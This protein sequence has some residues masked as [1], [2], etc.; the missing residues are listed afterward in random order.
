MH[1]PGDDSK[2]IPRA[3][4]PDA[5]ILLK[6]HTFF[7]TLKFK[8]IFLDLILGFHHRDESQSYFHK[9]GSPTAFEVHEVELGFGCDVFYIKAPIIYI[10][11]GMLSRFITSSF[12]LFVFVAFTIF[13]GVKSWKNQLVIW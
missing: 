13:V 2:T 7:E 6:A 3:S 11:W 9:Q 4:I 5:S 12:T 1:V 8:R 10:R